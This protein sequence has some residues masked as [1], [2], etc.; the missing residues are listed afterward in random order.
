M[1]VDQSDVV[2]RDG[3]TVRL[4]PAQPADETAVRAMFSRLSPESL[5][6][7]F[8]R[9]P[10]LPNL[11]V[12]GLL[13]ADPDRAFTLVAESRG[14]AC[15]LAGYMRDP[16]MPER[17]EVA[18]VTSDA[19][20]GRGI[21]TRMLE[22]LAD[23]ARAHRIRQFD[24]YVLANNDRM[25]G[26]FVDSGFAI[27]Q[28]L[29]AGVFHVVL[30]LDR[31]AGFEAQAAAR[32][33]TAAT[34]SVQA[35]L[36]P[37]S[38]AVIGASRERGKIGSEILHNLVSAGFTGRLFAV[39][40]RAAAIDGVPAFRS[41]A[42]IPDD[43]DLAMICVPARHVSDVVDACVAKRVRALVIISA[44]FGET[45][46]E[47]RALESS[48]VARIREAG[49]RLVGPNCMGVLNTATD[50]RLNATFAPVYPPAGRVA[51]STQS[52]ALGLAVLDYARDLGIGLSTF[53][54][55]GN[56]ADVSSNDLIQYWV[57]DPNTGVILLYVESFGNP[58]KFSQIARRV[59]RR[60]PIVAV[61]SGRSPAGARAASSH[62]GALA[63]SDAI[64]DA[65]FR[66]AG[67][68]RTTTLEEMFDVAR[69]LA[70]QP[71][72]QGRRVAILTNAGGPGILAAD[73]CEA[74]GLTLPAL[75]T[76]SVA[77]LRS[78]LPAAAAIGNPV[79]MI[80][81]ATADQYERALAT[82][83]DDDEVD[84]VLV[85]FIPP[86]VTKGEDVAAAVRRVARSRPAKPVLAIF[87][88]AQSAGPML[89]P[90]PCFSF[91]EAAAVALARASAY[92]EWRRQPETAP[93][94]FT[95]VDR[96]GARA[97]VD[98]GLQTGGGWL[99]PDD[100]Q[101]LLSAVRIPA[102]ASRGVTSED[103]AVEAAEKIG[104]PVVLKAIGPEILHKTEIGA[105]RLRLHTADDVREAWRD[106]T[107]RLGDA[108]TG[109][110]VQEMVVGGVEMLVG[111]VEDPTFGAVLACAT[112][113]TLAELLAD[114]QFRLHPLNDLDAAAMIDGLRGA[115]L[116]RGYR[117]A[118]CADER[119]LRDALLRLST[120]VELCPEIRELDVNPLVV[121]ERGVRALDVRIRIERPQPRPPSRRVS[122]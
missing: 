13:H 52:G 56:K 7:R 23:L 18:F 12:S 119:A 93:A 88:S 3:S 53:V 76:A 90:I 68:I 80:A 117:G 47:G 100:A 27:E 16:R 35:F 49:M 121:L 4:R 38:V 65:L 54:S 87:M 73:A 50:V 94:T 104:Y 103:R 51:M 98:R 55:V 91:P 109:A 99:T 70:T 97:I 30:D 37:R 96:D 40:P 66:Q 81:S 61:K 41:L 102:A 20:Q 45:G 2:L 85:I 14:E 39:H 46:A 17:A 106:L 43:I 24:A 113:G 92:G 67:V 110:L 86:L 34:A 95:D 114:M 10:K 21:G 112:G 101:A 79:D 69:L 120:L 6:S 115:R 64:V 108:M 72:P 107:R 89:D 71:V 74:S 62:T 48:I 60:K 11:D 15:A 33:E 31:T 58:R 19:L 28:Q 118:P 9:I 111:A 32:S 57:N 8:F 77:D 83:L 105:V 116:L 22:A 122:Y 29:E 78:F 75:S 25:M 1:T 84:S 82:L 44:G 5:Y 63:S 59:G 26:V 36:A 42:E